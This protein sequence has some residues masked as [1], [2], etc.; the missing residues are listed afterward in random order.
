MYVVFIKVIIILQLERYQM[1]NT[2]CYAVMIPSKRICKNGGLANLEIHIHLYYQ[3]RNERTR[4]VVL[5][6][7][8][9]FVQQVTFRY[10]SSMSSY[11]HSI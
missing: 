3:E 5:V 7:M 2:T 8:P 6:V 11:Q 9:C 4:H 10:P 1:L